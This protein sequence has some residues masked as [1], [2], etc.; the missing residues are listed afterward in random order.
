MVDASREVNPPTDRER[1]RRHFQKFS[2]ADNTYVQGWDDLWQT[3]YLPFDREQ[4]SPA[5]IDTLK[6]RK[7]LIENPFVVENGTRRRKRA[8]VPGCG[9]GYDVL[10]FASCG[11]DAYGLECSENALKACK[12]FAARSGDQYPVW[13]KEVG[14]GQIH[15][16]CGDFFKDDWSRDSDGKTLNF[17]L[18]Y[19]YT[20]LCALSP[21]LRPNWAFRMSQLLAPPP[22]VLICLEFPTAKEP[23]T[24]GPPFALRSAVYLQ[25][26]SRPGETIPYDENGYVI[27]QASSDTNE[28]ALLRVAHWKAERTHKIG[29]GTDHVSIWRH[30]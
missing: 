15:W 8:L 13:S 5:L 29:E 9:R 25:H 6:G 28:R 4:P 2:D 20:F 24:G 19:D 16:I 21:T 27:E 22:A 11:Y 10:L 3:G 26:L 30:K 12:E 14:Q 7:E 18:I 23:S 1:L 17:D